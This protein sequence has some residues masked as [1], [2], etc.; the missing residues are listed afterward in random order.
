MTHG[1]YQYAGDKEGRG[2]VV[3]DN[4]LGVDSKKSYIKIKPPAVIIGLID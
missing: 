2:I 1:H 4:P 3:L